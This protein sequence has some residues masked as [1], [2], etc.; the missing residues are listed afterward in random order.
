MT[1]D[2]VSDLLDGHL[3]CDISAQQVVPVLQLRVG[4]LPAHVP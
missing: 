1:A 3:I 2:H 4:R